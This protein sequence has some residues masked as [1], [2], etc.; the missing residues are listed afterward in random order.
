MKSI[1]YTTIIIVVNLSAINHTYGNDGTIICSITTTN[2]IFTG[3]N[4]YDANLE[5]SNGT[6]KVTCKNM[7]LS[8]NLSYVVT[9]KASSSGNPLS[10]LVK[11]GVETVSYSLFKDSTLSQ[12]LGDGTNTSTTITNTFTLPTMGTTTDTYTI[13]AK[14]PT[15]PLSKPM[16]YSDT[17]TATLI[18]TYQDLINI[19]IGLNL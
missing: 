6:I 14:I 3:Y 8:R 10:I 1:V 7:S 2:I 9:L 18:Y 15:Q 11:N 4:P 19:V 5:R 16:T 12:I 13:Y 17:I